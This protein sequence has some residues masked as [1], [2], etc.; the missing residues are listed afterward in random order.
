MII[1][2]IRAV[3]RLIAF[4]AVGNPMKVDQLCINICNRFFFSLFK[5]YFKF[6]RII[7]F[8]SVIM[9]KSLEDSM[10]VASLPQVSRPKTRYAVCPQ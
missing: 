9:G 3:L 6:L 1:S 10:L 4:A 5:I 2:R 8:V 7:Y